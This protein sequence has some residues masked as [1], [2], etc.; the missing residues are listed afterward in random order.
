MSI[1]AEIKS[2]FKAM[3]ARA[4]RRKANHIVRSVVSLR[5]DLELHDVTIT[6]KTNGKQWAVD[7]IN[8]V[9]GISFSCGWVDLE[10]IGLRHIHVTTMPDRSIKIYMPGSSL[11]IDCNLVKVEK[12]ITSVNRRVAI[13]FELKD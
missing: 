10:G 6:H 7:V 1:P 11:N 12:N 8:L 3:R 4:K 9:S 13:A 2:Q 5:H